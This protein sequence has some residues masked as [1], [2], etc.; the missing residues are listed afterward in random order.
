V[1]YNTGQIEYSA[2]RASAALYIVGVLPMSESGEEDYPLVESKEE[3]GDSYD[4]LDYL[5]TKGQK[6]ANLKILTSLT[7]GQIAKRLG[8]TTTSYKKII[9]DPHYS[10]FLKQLQHKLNGDDFGK[11]VKAQERFLRDRMFQEVA[12]RFEEPNPEE[13]LSPD[14]S[15]EERAMYAKR[16]AKNS[17]FKDLLRV[18]SGV[19]KVLGGVEE[20]TQSGGD[21]TELVR[22]V[23]EKRVKLISRRQRLHELVAEQGGDYNQLMTGDDDIAVEYSSSRGSPEELES[24]EEITTTLE[25]FSI[26][27]NK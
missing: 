26:K 9:N 10:N 18:W 21:E 24:V 4:P 13:D 23:Q 17:E 16:F 11:M 6:I 2:Y 12:S 20:S 7:D 19:N 5:S 22:R 27:R 8:L 25:E 1:I 14:A 3:L 15:M